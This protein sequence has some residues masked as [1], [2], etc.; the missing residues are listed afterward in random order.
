MLWDLMAFMAKKKKEKEI[1]Y[2]TIDKKENEERKH[3]K[4]IKKSIFLQLISI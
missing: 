3:S 2:N 4:M 1:K